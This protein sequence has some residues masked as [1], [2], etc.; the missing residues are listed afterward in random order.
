MIPFSR[1][2]VLSSE[3]PSLNNIIKMVKD[4][5]PSDETMIKYISRLKQKL[6]Q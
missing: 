1:Q 6:K 2:R 4:L 5:N 3:S